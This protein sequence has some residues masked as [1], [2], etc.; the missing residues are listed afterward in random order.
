M[1][2]S[3]ILD[4]PFMLG[5]S[6]QQYQRQPQSLDRDK[7]TR[8]MAPNTLISFDSG[9]ATQCTTSSN[10]N[11]TT[12]QTAPRTGPLRATMRPRALLPPPTTT[13]LLSV[14]GSS[15][16]DT[17][18]S[19]SLHR[20]SRKNSLSSQPS[21]YSESSQQ[22]QN[23]GFT[24]CRPHSVERRRGGGGGNGRGESV[25]GVQ[26]EEEGVGGRDYSSH[27]LLSSSPRQPP[28]SRKTR[29]LKRQDQENLHVISAKRTVVRDEDGPGM[30]GRHPMQDSTNRQN[31]QQQ[32][33]KAS[34]HARSTS[35]LN[36]GKSMATTETKRS[37]SLALM[38]PLNASR[39]NPMQQDTRS[40]LVR[41]QMHS[42]NSLCCTL[43]HNCNSSQLRSIAK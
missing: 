10:S 1:K 42:I 36:S 13:T 27:P 35:S 28:A 34:R 32:Q 37:I 7:V 41:G 16:A 11:N 17:A 15:N 6:L 2:L 8:G 43:L 5:Q 12:P 22:Q 19:L 9:N 38:P 39:L 4:H 25:R 18:S 29:D 40:A 3:E 14:S 26:G 20:R 33:Q 31:W 21:S 23:N 24:R 30:V